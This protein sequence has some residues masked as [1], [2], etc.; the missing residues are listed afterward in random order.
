MIRYL[1]HKE[2]EK[3]RW[4]RC[5]A[6]SQNTRIYGYSWYLDLVTEEQWDA[7]ILDDYLAVFPLPCNVKAGTAYLYT[8]FF[9]QQLG[10]F[11]PEA[12]GESLLK[13]FL[14]AIPEHY[15][16][17]DLNL[18][19]D[20]IMNPSNYG[21]FTMQ[22]KQNFELSLNRDYEELLAGFAENHRR[23][24]RKSENENLNLVQGSNVGKT[25]A[26]FR[27][28]RG[29]YIRNW[30][31][32]EY[33]LFGDLTEECR[34]H[35]RVE[36]REATD[37]GG[38][39]LAGLVFY[40]YAERAILI[41]SATGDKAKATG[42]MPAL[43]NSFIRDHSGTAMILDFEG[44]NDPGLARFYAGFG[45]QKIMYPH[46]YCDNLNVMIRWLRKLKNKIRA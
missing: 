25:V 26:L 29:K 11:S 14:D 5:I 17:C 23:N 1:T 24:I 40:I 41:F 28:E 19:S 21:R 46:I 7:L 12:I 43:I 35:A 2:I 13:E 8:P 15:K 37:K 4:D 36:I 20:N 30:H 31:N 6:Q 22:M 42:A 34:R 38:T 45:A 10:L 44:S 9:V 33:T 27:L 3:V 39:F 18:N 32:R 16:L